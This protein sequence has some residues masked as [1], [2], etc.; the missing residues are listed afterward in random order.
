[1]LT[2]FA[3]LGGVFLGA[4]VYRAVVKWR[5]TG[6]TTWQKLVAVFEASEALFVSYATVLGGN[7]VSFAAFVADTFGFEDAKV[8]IATNLPSEA[9]GVGIVALGAVY[10]IA[11]LRGV[12]AYFHPA[13]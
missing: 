6:G 8:W 12:A 10:F 11:K 3:V 13:A 2:F 5:A 7:A 1:M 4:M 9:V